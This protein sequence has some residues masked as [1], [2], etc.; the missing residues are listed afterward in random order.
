MKPTKKTILKVKKAL[1]KATN[2]N[3]NG[4]NVKKVNL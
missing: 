2:G 1:K 3:K 4:R